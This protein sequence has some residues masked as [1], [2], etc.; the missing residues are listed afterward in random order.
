MTVNDDKQVF[1]YVVTML[2]HVQGTISLTLTMCPKI[3]F[4][5]R[6]V[7]SISQSE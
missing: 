6:V 2:S 3:G 1:Y 5:Q 7:K 4:S